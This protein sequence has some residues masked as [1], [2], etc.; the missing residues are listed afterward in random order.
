MKIKAMNRD[1][2]QSYR[3]HEES[4]IGEESNEEIEVEGTI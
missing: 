1:Q 3:S 4:K 2:Y